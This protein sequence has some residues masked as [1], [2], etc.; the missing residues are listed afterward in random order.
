[1]FSMIGIRRI[2]RSFELMSR[3]P[4]PYSAALGVGLLRG[5]LFSEVNGWAQTNHSPGAG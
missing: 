1:M 3:L 2:T 4:S 5:L